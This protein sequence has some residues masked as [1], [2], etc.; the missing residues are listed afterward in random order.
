MESPVKTGR[1]AEKGGMWLLLAILVAVSSSALIRWI[2]FPQPGYEQAQKQAKLNA[3][4]DS[5]F[6]TL[7]ELGVK[8]RND[9]RYDEALSQF[10]EAGRSLPQL[11]ETQYAAL[12]QARLQ[13][14]DVYETAGN[15]SLAESVYKALADSALHDG[16]AYL[17]A[18]DEIALARYQDAETF[19]QHLTEERSR[20]LLM[21]TQA[22][23]LCLRDMR[24][25]SEARAA[26]QRAIDYLQSTA[27]EYDVS[28]V[29]QYMQLAETYQIETDW[30]H[31]EETITTTLTLCDKIISHSSGVSGA[32]NP[33]TT[34]QFDKNQL[35]YAMMEAYDQ[36]GKPE[37]ALST[38]DDLFNFVAQSSP[39]AIPGPHDRRDIANSALRIALK[40]NKQDAADTWR[41]RI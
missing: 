14:A 22:Q 17:H 23:S 11:N 29:A 21:A 39:Y 2:A 32:D 37:L 34:L 3:V 27:D 19:S 5:K 26:T 7:L 38:A 36:D 15:S 20:Y 18:R 16:A 24:R 10:E 25:F 31:L 41:H 9:G 4:Q 28:T 12:K 1:I 35:L 6:S 40:A 30:P 33:N 13:I 8:A